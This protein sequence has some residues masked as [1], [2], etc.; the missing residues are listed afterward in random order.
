MIKSRE[1]KEPIPLFAVLLL[2]FLSG[3][4]ALVYQVVWSRMMMHVFG[5]TA[6][7]LGTV[8]AAFM[9]GMAIG[10]WLIGK[11][12]DKS[13]NCLRL[14]A[15]L[16]IGLALTA[17]IAHILL[18]RIGPVHLMLHD[19]FGFSDA[20]FALIRFML[21]FVLVM[22][23]TILMGATLPVLTRFLV[24]RQTLVGVDLSTLYATNTFGAVAGVLITGF[25]LIGMY[26]I[27][28]PVYI[29][30]IGNLI[31]GCIAWLVSLRVAD[32][33][34]SSPPI[35]SEPDEGQASKFG[36][37][38]QLT[39][40]IILVG[41]GISGFTSFTYEI[42]WTRSL[43]F[44]LGNSTYA[45]TT[46]LSAFLSGIAIG[47]YMIRFLLRRIEDRA[48][49]F[50]WT[51]VFLGLFSAMALPL[52]FFIGD[53]QSLNEYVLKTTDQVFPLMFASFGV[54][55]L[56]ML[57]PAI[58]IGSTF[59]LVG[60]VVVKDRGKTGAH[61]GRLYAINTLGNVLG[62]LLPGFILLS[63]LGIQKGI[64]AMSILNVALGF[65]VLY[66]RFKRPQ[67]HPAWRFALP[68]ILLLTVAAM[69]RTPL[70]FQFP[71]DGERD[72]FKTVFY[73]EGPLATTKVY[74]NPKT[75]EKH[76]SVD[77][78]VIGGT[79][80]AE[81]KQLLLAHL[82]KLLLKDVSTELSVGLGSG[83]LA[84]ESALHSGVDS[85]TAVE[86]EPGVVEGAAWFANENHNVLD[87][88][89][90][91]VT[92]DDIGNYLR[93]TSDRYQ[94]ITADEKTAD[95][96][97][98]NGFSYSLEYYDLLRDHLAPGGLVAQWVPATLP[99][100]Q[101]QMILK[102]FTESFP[103]V[104]LWYFLPAYKK[105][106]FNSILVGSN[107]RIVLDYDH[108]DRELNRNPAAFSSLEPYGLTSAQAVLPHFVANEKTIRPAV[109]TALINSLDHPHYEFYYPWEYVIDRDQQIITNH[110]FIRELKLKAYPEFWAS[111]EPGIQDSMRFKKTLEAEDRY[112]MGF[113]KFMSGLSLMENYRLFDEILALAPW[114]DSLRARIYSQYMHFALNNPNPAEREWLLKRA[115]T[116]YKQH[117][118][119]RVPA[120]SL[121]E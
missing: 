52:L 31:I 88:P 99:P 59:P 106:P 6:V 53:P 65:V 20:T 40:R 56:V 57:V 28:I 19:L 118:G 29:A 101:Y 63:W 81:Y 36:S 33:S 44:I 112:L 94:V 11:A 76:M 77:G 86:I 93:T 2:Y 32:A 71:S 95:E 62:A 13:T 66:L 87:N 92:I 12:A 120:N 85:I 83:M 16:E 27:H 49:I 50:G 79:G 108:I 68:V 42:Y 46:M 25:F 34:Q 38:D 114:N 54:A 89:R 5:S 23:P 24:R 72:Y 1:N 121:A 58:L 26:G 96:Y 48:A 84:G 8:L 70:Q 55:F 75:M 111:L 7:A 47:G 90:L 14:Y 113:Q 116:L 3:A 9:A 10:S 109:K 51:Q 73:R 105:G 21:A 4:L 74:W 80:M 61:V 64:L 43:V 97:A 104:Q 82:P 30:V 41:L 45:M 91:T 39:F 22:A 107:E 103:N 100:R 98:S 119:K 115:N 102:T 35:A 37:V 17:L 78:I 67:R 60:Q 110:N 117:G 18:S 15:F 69:N